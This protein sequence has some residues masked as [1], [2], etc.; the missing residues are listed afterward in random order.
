MPESEIIIPAHIGSPGLVTGQITFY[1]EDHL[2]ELT[3]NAE[4]AEAEERRWRQAEQAA[5]RELERQKKALKKSTSDEA[6]AAISVINSHILALHDPMVR[7][8]IHKKIHR[9]NMPAARAVSEVFEQLI[10]SF[11]KLPDLLFQE[12]ARDIED[13]RSRLLSWVTRRKPSRLSNCSE[14]IFTDSVL[15]GQVLR[16]ARAGVK[17]IIVRHASPTSHELIIA[18]ALGIPFLYHPEYE[19]EIPPGGTSAILDANCGK[20]ILHPATLPVT[21]AKKYQPRKMTENIAIKDFRLYLNLSLPEELPAAIRNP[22]AGV[23]LFRSELPFLGQTTLP[24]YEKQVQ[25]YTRMMSPFKGKPF[26][27]RLFDLGEDKQLN[28]RSKFMEL[29]SIRR[30]LQE[31]ELLCTQLKALLAAQEQART[32]L[33]IL[34]P[35]VTLTEELLAVKKILATL[36]APRIPIAAMIETPAAVAMVPF[37][38]KIVSAYSVGSNDL[39]QFLTATRR[40]DDRLPEY[41]DPL[42]E[43]NFEAL[44]N[45]LSRAGSRAVTICGELAAQPGWLELLLALGYRKFSVSTDRVQ[46]LQ[47]RAAS[48]DLARSQ[49][50]LKEI[51]QTGELKKRQALLKKLQN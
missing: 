50:I 22:V 47:Y 25:V 10:H 9:E 17:G 20:L 5:T 19:P 7:E 18:K 43:A 46:D 15:P 36:K 12:K 3:S 13:I 27:F 1:R 29:R 16:L 44:E 21:S 51:R 24:S 39:I 41:S 37:W 45:I 23:G 48:V 30:L 8:E 6:S 28:P 33:T 38:N 34:I 11:R 40:N 2:A 14:I 42:Q 31:P 26:N 32:R 49:T 35:F 4:S